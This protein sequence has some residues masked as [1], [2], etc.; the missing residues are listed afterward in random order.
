MGW[1]ARLLFGS[2]AF[3]AVFGC[4][5]P[6]SGDGSGDERSLFD[7]RIVERLIADEEYSGGLCQVKRDQAIA[8]QKDPQIASS[9]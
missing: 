6:T 9:Q 3:L 4:R 7:V 2:V 1:M 8:R 5:L